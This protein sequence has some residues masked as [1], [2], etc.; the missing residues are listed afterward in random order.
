M[1][2]K[3][4]CGKKMTDKY[5]QESYAAVVYDIQLKWIFLQ[6]RTKNTAQVFV[7]LEKLYGRPF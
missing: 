3:Y 7:G 6:R 5:P 1:G 2:E 4:S